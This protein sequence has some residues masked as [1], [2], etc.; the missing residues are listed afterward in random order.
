MNELVNLMSEAMQMGISLPDMVQTQPVYGA[1]QQQQQQQQ[2]QGIVV[3]G[4]KHVIEVTFELVA[5]SYKQ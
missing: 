3:Q 4:F 5:V 1:Q 2:P